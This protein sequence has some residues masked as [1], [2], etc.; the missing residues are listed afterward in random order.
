MSK[1]F[2][3]LTVALI[4]GMA[5]Y[6]YLQFSENQQLATI[7]IA[8]QEWRN[9]LFEQVELNTTQRLGFEQKIVSLES[10]LSSANNQILNLSSALQKAQDIANPDIESIRDQ[11]QRDLDSELLRNDPMTL[12]RLALR[13][14][15]PAIIESMAKI[16]V[17]MNYRDFLN[18]LN[19]DEN[20]KNQIEA[21]LVTVLG[22]QTILSMQ[23][24]VGDLDRAELAEISG[25]GYITDQLATL[26][27][28]EELELLEEYQ[29]DMPARQ[30]RSVF[31]TQ[32]VMAA[33]E[34]SDSNR[35]YLVDMMTDYL[36]PT[37]DNYIPTLNSDPE[38][39]EESAT[40]NY[41]E[42]MDRMRSV[43]QTELNPDEMQE[44][45]LVLDQIRSV[46]EMTLEMSRSRS[47]QQ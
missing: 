13:S 35:S 18:S 7:M 16:Q 43:I 26:L 24:A 38:T 22:E 29:T 12:S 32:V 46:M 47:A 4:L 2:Q 21:L 8:Q 30:L 15:T 39:M 42:A 14:M 28:S 37:G 3:V 33:P 10:S 45:D 34:M 31:T 17:N 9:Q 5:A 27:T 41:L 6:S 25:N 40:E 11:I 44:A 23:V 1:K 20:R 36:S 19:I